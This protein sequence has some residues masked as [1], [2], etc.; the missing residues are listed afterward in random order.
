MK[1]IAL[2]ALL[3]MFALA[4]AA[5]ADTVVNWLHLS[6]N[7]GE[8]AGMADAIKAYE[9]MNPGVTIKQQ[10]L[11]NEAF[12][13]KLTT[14]LQSDQAPDFF[15]SWAAGDLTAQ[16]KAGVMRPIDDLLTPEVK[17]N[18]GPAGL[19]AF[20]RGGHVYGLAQNVAQVVLWY[21]KKL[22]AQAGVDPASMSTWD[23]FIAGVKKIKAAGI[24]PIALG[25]KDKWPAHFYYAYLVTRIAGEQGFRD[26]EAG[27]GDG[28]AAPAF[29]EAGKRLLELAQL[30]P[31]QPGYQ[32]AAY[33]DASGYFGD[34]KAAL[35]L[36]GDWEYGAMKDNSVSKKGI[37]D[38]DL[39]IMPFPTIPGGMGDPSDV[40]GGIN[41]WVF[42][43][44]ASDAAVKFVEYYTSPEVMAKMAKVGIYIPIAKGTSS[45][46]ANK[47]QQQMAEAAAKAHWLAIYFDQELGP[48]VGG[49][50]NDIAAALASNSITAEDAAQQ[51]QGSYKENQ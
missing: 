51:L 32:A 33:G 1:R 17:A 8:L 11:E 29:I 44:N 15:Y 3:G 25:A 49:T 42:S 31:F 24:T 45:S 22:L 16:V 12:K 47:F 46:L 26:A 37:P 5:Q 21:N 43:K 34:G 40:L 50:V 6:N 18:I 14:L 30:E 2:A 35:D 13:A 7:P 19:N 41:G 20:T 39:G 4:P 28:F 10:Y 38:E 36:M 48:A 27:K 23:G 9:A